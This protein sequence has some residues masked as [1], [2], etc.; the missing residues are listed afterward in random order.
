M[1]REVLRF[2]CPALIALPVAAFAQEDPQPR[3][4]Q[5]GASTADER[6]CRR[7]EEGARISGEIVV[8][9]NREEDARYRL[10]PR[11]EAAN[12]HAEHTRDRGDPRAPDFAPPPCQP[13]LLTFCPTFG[14]LGAP[15]VIVDFSRL[16]EAPEGSDADLIARGERPQ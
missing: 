12:R 14:P 1:S 3:A 13:N 8:C 11:D 15:P 9:G 4:G 7:R 2:A 10:G 16:P 6:D 5:A